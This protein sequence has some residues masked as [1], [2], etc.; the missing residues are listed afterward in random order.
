[1]QDFCRLEVWQA[2]RALRLEVYRLTRSFPDDERWVLVPQIRRSASSIGWNIAEGSARGSD[3]D[4]ARCLQIAAGSVAECHD[5]LI[6][7][8]DLNTCRM[9]SSGTSKRRCRPSRAGSTPFYATSGIARA[10]PVRP[11]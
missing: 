11:A 7:A 4:F 1:M 8:R 9:R 2:A 10:G 3:A 5:Q 6:Q